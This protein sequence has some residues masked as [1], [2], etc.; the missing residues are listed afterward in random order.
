[1]GDNSVFVDGDHPAY[2]EGDALGAL[3]AERWGA[4]KTYIRQL[5]V[6]EFLNVWLWFGEE[7]GA[8]E[9]RDFMFN[10]LNTAF[11]IINFPFGAILKNR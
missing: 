6:M 5:N 11:R 2:A 4:T 10:K 9:N 3:I 7:L 8:G 1:M